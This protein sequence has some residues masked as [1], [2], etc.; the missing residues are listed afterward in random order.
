MTQLH[1]KPEI[2]GTRAGYVIRYTCPACASENII[3]NK[4][5]RDHFKESRDAS[6]KQCR[7]RMRVIAPSV[8]GSY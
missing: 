5:P 4:T 7:K 6:C 3:I 8:K 2:S 1:E